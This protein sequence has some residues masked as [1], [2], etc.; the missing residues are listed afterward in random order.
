M[1]K[2]EY[3]EG[4]IN[5]ALKKLTKAASVCWDGDIVCSEDPATFLV[6]DSEGDDT[7][8]SI[9][10]EGTSLIL[11]KLGADGV[12]RTLGD[13]NKFNQIADLICDAVSE[14]AA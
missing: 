1:D 2:P 11:R 10:D 14:T 7:R 3:T 6:L 12:Y 4:R 9:I 5:A 8:L 13:A